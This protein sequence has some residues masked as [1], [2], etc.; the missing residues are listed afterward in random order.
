MEKFGWGRLTVFS[1]VDSYF[2]HVESLLLKSLASINVTFFHIW[3]NVNMSNHKDL[4]AMSNSSR[5]FF[6]N[7]YENTARKIL[8]EAYNHKI[9]YPDY[10]WLLYG[11]YTENWLSVVHE[12][13]PTELAQSIHRGIL[14]QQHQSVKCNYHVNLVSY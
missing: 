8:C 11:W 14:I 6:I 12:C 4:F 13:S 10:A 3:P 7:A 2:L 1:E 5:I 9:Y